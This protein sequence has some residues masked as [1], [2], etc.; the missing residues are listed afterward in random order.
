[1]TYIFADIALESVY[2]SSF[3]DFHYNE[4]YTGGGGGGGL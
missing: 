3:Q 1:M 2:I 4:H